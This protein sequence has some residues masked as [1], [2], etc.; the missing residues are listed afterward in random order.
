MFK[1]FKYRCKKMGH[2]DCDMPGLDQEDE[3]ALEKSPRHNVGSSSAN[4][5]RING[6][7]SLLCVGEV[8]MHLRSELQVL[9][10][11]S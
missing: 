6:L 7:H 4:L 1:Y 2:S 10:R 3:R 8:C 11:I 5:I 9:C